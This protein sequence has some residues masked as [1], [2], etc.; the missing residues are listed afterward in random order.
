M[1]LPGK[2][3][4]MQYVYKC[5]NESLPWSTVRNREDTLAKKLVMLENYRNSIIFTETMYRNSR[6]HGPVSEK[7]N[8]SDS[9]A[10]K[11]IVR[12]DNHSCNSHIL[13]ADN[14][15]AGHATIEHR[16]QLYESKFAACMKSTTELS[17]WL[18]AF[19]K[20]GPPFALLEKEYS[21]YTASVAASTP[22]SSPTPQK[23]RKRNAVKKESIT[24]SVKASISTMIKKATDSI[25]STRYKHENQSKYDYCEMQKAPRN[26]LH[27]SI[28]PKGS[29]GQQRKKALLNRF[30]FY[31]SS[32]NDILPSVQIIDKSSIRVVPVNTT[33]ESQPIFSNRTKHRALKSVGNPDSSKKWTTEVNNANDNAP[34]T[35]SKTQS[36]Q[37]IMSHSSSIFLTKLRS[38]A[39]ND[40]T[41]REAPQHITQPNIPLKTKTY[42]Y[43]LKSYSTTSELTEDDDSRTS[44]PSSPTIDS[45][46]SS[47]LFTA[48]ANTCCIENL[49]RPYEMNRSGV[50]KDPIINKMPKATNAYP[51]AANKS[52]STSRYRTQQHQQAQ[53]KQK[54]RASMLIASS[55]SSLRYLS[56]KSQFFERQVC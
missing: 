54:N 27:I 7:K 51:T 47:P 9:V 4:I 6:Q 5:L 1:T 42:Q 56:Q 50:E 2:P 31:E 29:S 53:Q 14:V 24:P 30:S 35:L 34:N 40:E 52:Q 37:T 32:R 8:I 49:L 19:K 11:E 43:S 18:K 23:H 55:L 41:A 13:T 17:A 21:K 36:D 12:Q 46:I 28:D 48:Y 15:Y 20:K 39:S 22:V 44:F 38:K 45:V 26:T 10:I 16:I 25:K 3:G 33:L